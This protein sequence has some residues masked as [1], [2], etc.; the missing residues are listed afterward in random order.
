MGG[1]ATVWMCVS[2]RAMLRVCG[3]RVEGHWCVSYATP[4]HCPPLPHGALR[5]MA[6]HCRAEKGP[7]AHKAGMQSLALSEIVRSTEQNP[8]DGLL[9]AHLAEAWVK[10]T[11]GC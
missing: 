4:E 6:A 3:V 11:V 5:A 7:D 2:I 9:W 1:C 10:V 8:M